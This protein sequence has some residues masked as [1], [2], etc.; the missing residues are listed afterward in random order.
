MEKVRLSSKGERIAAVVVSAFMLGL[1]ALLFA[2][3]RGDT[4]GLIIVAVCAVLLLG[5]LGIY[6]VNVFSA[7]CT[8]S[9]GS[10]AVHISGAVSYD[11][12]MSGVKSIV[13]REVKLG[14]VCSRDIDFI[15]A[16][17]AV[18]KSVATSFTVRGGS[19]AEPAARKIAEAMGV[20]F[21]PSLEP[22]TYDAKARKQRSVQLR[23]EKRGKKSAAP[24]KLP[25]TE[26][27]SEVNY[28]AMDDMK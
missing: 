28:D 25:E 8:V 2:A 12:D 6:I 19:A 11:A 16:D 7:A 17:G 14:P 20:S 23:E 5:A 9:S 24:E 15:D 21:T 22:W 1:F 10:G 13:T 3:L 27:K 18:I 4:A 26:D